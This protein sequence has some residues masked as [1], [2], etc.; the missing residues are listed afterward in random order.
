MNGTQVEALYLAGGKSLSAGEASITRSE[1]GLAYVEKTLD[2]SY[3]I[4]NPSP[5]EATVTVTLTSLSGLTAFTLSGA[6]QRETPLE[7]AKQ[8]AGPRTFD[9][10]AGEKIGLSPK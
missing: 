3:I 1:P 10:K 2:G 9:L 8:E 6:G 5:T 4:A 7:P